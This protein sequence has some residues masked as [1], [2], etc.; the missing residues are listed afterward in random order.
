[1]NYTRETFDVYR[2]YSLPASAAENRCVFK[3]CR[4]MST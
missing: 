1:L 2:F 3:I 4:G